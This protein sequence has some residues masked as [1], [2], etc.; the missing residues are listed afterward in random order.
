[1]KH[2]ALVANG[3]IEEYERIKRRILHADGVIAVDGGL[4]H[5]EA[6]GIVPDELIGDFDSLDERLKEK[7]SYLPCRR[8]P[9]EK[10][11]SDLELA[12]EASLERYPERITLFAAL[13]GRIDHA[14]SNLYLLLRYPKL[15]TIVSDREELFAVE[16][17]KVV[18]A[19]P[20]EGVSLFCLTGKARGVTTRGLKWELERAEIDHAFFSLS[21]ICIGSTFSLSV[22]EGL[23]LCSRYDA[24]PAL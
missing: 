12:V 18:E 14:L 19:S 9:R 15:L 7:Y 11:A 24:S 23:L 2:I 8:Y 10:D 6:M 16:G 13:G 17:E 5:C 1:M 21:N 3:E 20:G 22:E 4:A